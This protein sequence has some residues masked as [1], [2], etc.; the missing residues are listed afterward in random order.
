MASGTRSGKQKSRSPATRRKAAPRKKTAAKSR[1]KGLTRSIMPA[2]RWGLIFWGAAALAALVLLFLWSQAPDSSY[3]PSTAFMNGKEPAGGSIVYEEPLPK[4]MP[5]AQP[6]LSMVDEAIFTALRQTGVSPQDTHLALA[7]GPDGEVSLI[8]AQLPPDISLDQAAATLEKSLAG[9][10]AKGVWRFNGHGREFSL[11]LAGRLTHKVLLESGRHLPKPAPSPPAAPPAPPAAP[12]PVGPRLA[13][14]IDDI[15]YQLGQAKELINLGLPLTLSILP[16]S[17]H[18]RKIAQLARKQGLE[19]ML[20]LPMEPRGYP[21][22]KPGPGALLTSMTPDQ[23]RQTTLDDLASVPG[24]K[25]ANNHMGSRFTEHGE[26]LR[27]VMQVLSEKGMFFIDSMTSANSR[28]Y[29]MARTMGLT[30]ARR[31]IFLDHDHTLPAIRR[32]LQ[33]ILSLA[34][35]GSQVV[36]IGHPHQATIQALSEFAPRLKKEARMVTASQFLH[37]TALAGRGGGA[38]RAAGGQLDRPAARQ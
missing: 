22:L 1:R 12:S 9:T 32:Q 14:I 10:K 21:D 4:S 30:A 16:H 23:L 29:A 37:G 25:G 17:P 18:G 36:A 7:H 8:K 5:K 31:T 2:K 19:V 35:R 6:D 13:I 28:A 34:K 27:P 15:G 20:H 24:A 3:Q 11:S 33:R 38:S 26:A